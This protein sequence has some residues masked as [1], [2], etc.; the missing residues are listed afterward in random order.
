[1]SQPSLP[2]ESIFLQALELP[3]AADRAAYLGQACGAD[4]DLRAAVEALLR[5]H[6]QSGDLLD[7]PD[8]PN[9]T[10][11]EIVT[12]AKV[13]ADL[14]FLAPSD[15][16]G[17]LGRLG[18]YEVRELI[19]RGGMG[20]V[21]KAFDEQLHRVV[22]VKVMAAQLATN[23]T[24]RVRFTREARAAAAVAHDHVVTIHAVEEAGGLP[25]LVMQCVAGG[26][27]QDRLDRAGPLGLA[28]VLRIGM[29]AASGLAAAH[30]QGLVHRDVKPANILLED[31]V[32]R[33]KLTD[34]GL[35][36]AA[37]DAS[38]S[39]SGMIAGTPQY[40]SPEQAEGKLVDARSDLFSL[41]SVLYAMCTGRPP[42]RAGTSIA[43]LKRLCEE[44]PTPIR[45]T[46]PEIPDWLVAVVAKL[47]AKDPA[48]RF[49][50]AAEVA[51][52]LGQQLAHVQQPS[53]IPL[54]A[55]AR[56]PEDP[57]APARRRRWAVA[58]A[59]LV[60]LVTAL[61]TTEATGITN[62]RTTIVR[63]FTPDG[64]LV[65]ATDDPDVKVTVEAD[66]G[67]V[68]TGAGLEEI[69]LR[70]GSYRLRATKD[71]TPVALDRDLVTITRGDKQVVR[72]RREAGVPAVAAPK[73]EPGSFV[74]LGGKG[75]A[76]KQFDTLAEAVASATGGDT[77]EVRGNG[78]FVLDHLAFNYALTIRAASGAHPVFTSDPKREQPPRFLLVAPRA[79]R[80]E[81]LE[82]RST[83]SNDF[84]LLYTV[85][86]L[87]VANCRF[88]IFD[89][90]ALCIESD[91]SCT[92]RNCELV[93]GGGAAL[94]IRCDSDA[95]SEVANSIVVGHINLDE[96]D[97]T[98]GTA[99]QFR[100]N[101][102][103]SPHRNTFRHTLQPMDMPPDQ[104]RS[105]PGKRLQVALTENLLASTNGLYVLVQE[106]A[107]Q[108]RF[109]A[110]GL[111]AWLPRRVE[112]SE[113]RNIYRP[114]KSYI[115][116]RIAGPE[117]NPNLILPLSRGN[118][119]ADW[120][121][122]W[123]LKDTGSSE[124]VIR[125]LGG[126]L[127]AKALA[128]AAQLHPEDFRLRPDSAGHRAGPDG[129]DLGADIDLVGPG[130]AYERWK[131]TPEY[132]KW[133]EETRPLK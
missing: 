81:G 42:F 47:H 45:E 38:L 76:G 101:T 92:V 40:M 12:D 83:Y 104:I 77:I 89:R 35:A 31:G 68:I 108:P 64:T 100:G 96:F 29:Q 116:A 111:E 1:M 122:F 110:D 120:N 7:L 125:F 128:D 62:V 55:V 60:A 32:E 8:R 80:L 18:H 69:R 91:H 107:F 118:D 85:G 133:L 66:G 94:A 24:A 17:V 90:S 19:G 57:A 21:L 36:R 6:E 58:T 56:S 88:Q 65:V 75:A 93:S 82:F 50:S 53:V 37:A 84:R 22:A 52:V 126:D 16:P 130:P 5:A 127:L 123:G 112:W 15:K 33:V 106:K 119:F 131:K 103:V 43:V 115:A 54:P 79:L 2:E 86:P 25:Y 23:A 87:R 49:Q 10:Q 97:V 74:V 124:G 14:G 13:S 27:L 20:V 51:S 28:A 95:P 105:L 121:R 11:A 4:R 109:D 129:K 34:F 71:G 39:Q 78:P 30:A 73:A 63:V 67:L 113:Q 59:V 26:S 114:V 3:T 61:G 44:T 9:E 70:P 72:V 132:Q 46:N 99:V 102:F 117:N 48:S 98:R 41:G